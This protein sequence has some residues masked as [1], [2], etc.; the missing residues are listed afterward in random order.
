MLVHT[1]VP[2]KYRDDL[3]LDEGE[4]TTF[5][6]L[7]ETQKQPRKS[8]FAPRVSDQLIVNTTSIHNQLKRK[9]NEIAEDIES[10]E[11][12]NECSSPPPE[13]VDSNLLYE[14]TTIPA[15]SR[16][17]RKYIVVKSRNAKL[18]QLK[19]ASPKKII[20]C[21]EPTRTT[22]TEEESFFLTEEGDIASSSNISDVKNTQVEVLSNPPPPATLEN[23][24]EFIFN[25]E[26]YVQ[27]PKRVFI[28]EK[29]RLKA[30]G[31]NYRKMLVELR[32]KIDGY[33]QH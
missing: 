5:T 28:A 20:N 3:V 22:K 10:I 21:I 13:V 1:A 27:M 7:D 17:A 33:L 2:E 14:E 4:P 32:A 26:L 11:Y 6:I 8:K 24:T 12:V 25:G 30:E 16:E 15:P 31:E 9:W 23:C 19:F 18:T 29:E